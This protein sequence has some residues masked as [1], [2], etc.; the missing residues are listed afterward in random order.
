MYSR[1]PVNI[2]CRS[3]RKYLITAL[4]FICLLNT[5]FDEKIL[6]WGEFF[7]F[8]EKGW[9]GAIYNKVEGIGL[10]PNLKIAEFSDPNC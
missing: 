2:V 4:S 9:G 5:E 7:V 8:C 10:L 6:C 3:C 1:I